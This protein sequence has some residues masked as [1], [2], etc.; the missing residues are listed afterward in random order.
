MSAYVGGAGF[1]QSISSWD[2]I[3]GHTAPSRYDTT[4]TVLRKIEP[5]Q[6][7][8]GELDAARLRLEQEGGTLQE[9]SELIMLLEKELSFTIDGYTYRISLVDVKGL[10][11]LF[12]GLSYH[13]LHL[14]VRT[15]RS[16]G[17][18]TYYL[19]R[20]KRD[21]LSD[22]SMIL[23][24]LHVSPG[25]PMPNPRLVRL[26]GLSGRQQFYIRLSPFRE[27][28]TRKIRET[29]GDSP[30]WQADEVLCRVRWAGA[31]LADQGTRPRKSERH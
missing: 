14:E 21:Y 15:H 17:M 1:A 7:H 25:Y 20:L 11:D 6:R 5:L 27:A 29:L 2:G 3:G 16:N 23:E 19:C 30:R 12:T 31:G 22:Y 18:P 13:G 26:M 4:G 9:V 24:D 28:V 8:L 10:R